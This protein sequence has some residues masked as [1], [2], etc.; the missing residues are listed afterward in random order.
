MKPFVRA[1][2]LAHRRKLRAI[3]RAVVRPGSENLLKKSIRDAK[4]LT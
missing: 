1:S 2:T 4:K 3:N